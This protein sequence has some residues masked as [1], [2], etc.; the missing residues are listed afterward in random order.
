MKV[1]QKNQLWLECVHF[2]KWLIP[3]EAGH[4]S[5]VLHLSDLEETAYC[6]K[7]QLNLQTSFKGTLT[8]FIIN[9]IK[10]SDRT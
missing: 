1:T 9:I 8:K 3:R 4:R 6:E 5:S 10:L 2:I 7:P